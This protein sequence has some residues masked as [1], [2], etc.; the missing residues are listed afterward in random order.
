MTRG[1]ASDKYQ[2]T[3]AAPRVAKNHLWKERHIMPF[4]FKLSKR[5]ARLKP[6]AVILALAALVA[7]DPA[8]RSHTSPS[9]PRFLTSSGTPDG[10]TDRAAAAASATPIPLA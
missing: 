7:C 2:F 3:L 8:D 9:H 10:L 4:T 1:A 6:R 5:L